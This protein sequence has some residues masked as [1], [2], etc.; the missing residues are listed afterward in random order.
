MAVQASVDKQF[1][2]ADAEAWGKRAAQTIISCFPFSFRTSLLCLL[3]PVHMVTRVAS[4]PVFPLSSFSISPDPELSTNTDRNLAP[5][6]PEIQVTRPTLA[7]HPYST[8]LRPKRSNAWTLKSPRPVHL[9]HAHHNTHFNPLQS[10]ELPWWRDSQPTRFDHPIQSIITHLVQSQPQPATSYTGDITTHFL[11]TT[12]NTHPT[13]MCYNFPLFF[14]Q[15]HCHCIIPTSLSHHHHI[16]LI[17]LWHHYCIIITPLWHHSYFSSLWH[18]YNIVMT[19]SCTTSIYMAR[20][21]LV[22]P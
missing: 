12:S 21:S 19:S 18:C 3:L 7:Y 1:P 17:P 10:W 22:F 6:T 8:T 20:Y 16:I 4:H 14:L 11:I 9:T 15:P 2:Y 13:S 5:S